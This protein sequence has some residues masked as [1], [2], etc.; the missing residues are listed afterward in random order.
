MAKLQGLVSYAKSCDVCHP[1]T[2]AYLESTI[3]ALR[4]DDPKSP[5]AVIQRFYRHHHMLREDCKTLY[6]IT[7]TT[8][9]KYRNVWSLVGRELVL[10]L[11]NP[12]GPIFSWTAQK[13]KHAL[14]V[15]SL[16]L[17]IDRKLFVAGL[18]TKVAGA[19]ELPRVPAVT[20]ERELSSGQLVAP[21]EPPLSPALSLP[22][23]SIDLAQS[24]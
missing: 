17:D 15:D 12:V 6:K 5:I 23:D 13:T 11:Q 14:V 22:L 2:L 4:R 16:P 8:S 10:R 18:L 20:V 19:Q 1:F 7:S 3:D 24:A 9:T 21:L